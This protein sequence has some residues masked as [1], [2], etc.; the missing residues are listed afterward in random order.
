MYKKDEMGDFNKQLENPLV[1]GERAKEINRLKDALAARMAAT[2][3]SIKK[4]DRLQR[5]YVDPEGTI[6]PGAPLV[7]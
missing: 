5:Q 1:T 6:L 4:Y 2:Q 3:E 7:T